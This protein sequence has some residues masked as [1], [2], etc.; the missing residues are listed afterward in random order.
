MTKRHLAWSAIALLV[1]VSLAVGV[2]GLSGV[3]TVRISEADLKQ[4]LDAQLPKE[5]KGVKLTKATIGIHERDLSIALSLEG[6][7]VGQPYALE[8]TGV[9]VPNYMREKQAFYFRPSKLAVTKLELSG[10]SATDKA[11]KFTDRYVT[12]P[13][14]KERI[15]GTL[16]GMQ[17]WVE[18][19]IEPQALALFGA[20]PLYRPKN[21]MKGIIIKATL[22]SLTVENG[23]I[24]L[25]FSLMQLTKTVLLCLFALLVALGFMVVL[26][27]NPGWGVPV[28]LVTMPLE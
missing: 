19:N 4:R 2:F 22:E 27:R 14:L 20:M 23:T 6:K 18:D 17:R 13:K 5:L 1:L 24:V 25:S 11:G 12:D 16:P 8:A 9:G 10:E 7:F 15:K 26:L 3:R 21:D 28:L